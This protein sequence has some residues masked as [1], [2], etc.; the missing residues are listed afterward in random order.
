MILDTMCLVVIEGRHMV[1]KFAVNVNA[2]D[3]Q[4]YHGLKNQTGSVGSVENQTLIQYDCLR[5]PNIKEK[6]K[7]KTGAVKQ[8]LVI[9]EEKTSTKKKK[10]LTKEEETKN[11]RFVGK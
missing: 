6:K 11:L 7:L 5:N 10:N 1:T 2:R 9:E 3:S 8:V 4:L